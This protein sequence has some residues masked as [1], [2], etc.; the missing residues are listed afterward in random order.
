MKILNLH[1]LW[2]DSSSFLNNLKSEETKNHIKAHLS[3]LAYSYFYNYKPSPRILRQHCV[4]RN[5][6]KNY[7]IV[8]T[9]PDKGNWFVISNRKLYYSSVEGIISDTS[10]F[11]KLNEDPALKR[12][13][14]LQGFLRN[15][16]QKTFLMKLNM[17]NCILLVL[18]LLVSKVLLKYANSPLVIH[19]LN[20]VRLFHL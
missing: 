18:L 2:K 7:D 17:I 11:E 3:Y 6:R 12:E 19:F 15:L 4:L 5:L 16:K 13:A 20:F 10:Q 14:S 1:Y 8:I 9:K